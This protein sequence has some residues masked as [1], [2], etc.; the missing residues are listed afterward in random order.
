MTPE[1]KT[2][3]HAWSMKRYL[4]I[5]FLTL[6][7]LVL[8]LGSWSVFTQMAGAV[9]GNGVVEV[10]TK[11]QVVQHATGGVVGEILVKEGQVVKAGQTV[12]IFDD[13]FD[14][15]EL[16]V[17][18]SQLFPLLGTRARLIAEQDE[19]PKPIFDKELVER[20][21]TSP[22]EAEVIRS[23]SELLIARRLTRD[24]QIDQLQE[25]KAQITKQIDGL[26]ARIDALGKQLKFLSEDIDA[27][28]KLL[29]Q[30]LTQKSRVSALE[31]DAAQIRGNVSESQSSIAEAKARIA[32]M[33][34][35]I[36]NVSAQMRE[37]AIKELGDTD[38]RASEL[39][40]RR[41]STLATLSRVEVTAPTEG[42]VFNLAVHAVRQVI[43][44]AEPIME[45][46]P[47]N[48]KLV[49]SVQVPPAQIDQV[50]VGQ[51]VIIRFQSFDHRHTPDLNGK[52]RRISADIIT[53]ERT[54]QSYYSVSISLLPGE[55]KFLG[56]KAEIIPGMPVDAFIRT[57]ERTPFDYL[58]R[59]LTSYFGKSMLE[60]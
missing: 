11:R 15:A 48:V 34:L 3:A 19:A 59:P 27:Q 7:F 39:R 12:L 14:R 22:R 46:V 10:E 47:D 23:Q 44:A 18:E 5:G 40:E 57:T 52:V 28:N 26:V 21:K 55:E 1:K 31:R 49:V 30:G 33:E 13:T 20:A 54:G 32:E 36:I 50:H 16:A 45:I 9:V 8:G 35:A 4:I 51:N 25:R 41:I 6:A 53:N 24:K 17:I 37:D 29:K 58:V 56:A 60:R 43:R 42:K 2:P 38:A